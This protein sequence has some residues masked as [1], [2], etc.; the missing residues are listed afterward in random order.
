MDVWYVSYGSN[1]AA[2]RFGCYLS[3]GTPAGARRAM[4]GCRDARPPRR[5]RPT[6]LPWRLRFGGESTVWGGGVAYLDL[7]RPGTTYARAWRITVGQFADVIAQEND[8]ACGTVDVDTALLAAG[9]ALF[10]GESYGRVVPLPT[11]EGIPAVTFT[12]AELPPHRPPSPAY[13]STMRTGLLELSL[14][15]VD[16]DAYLDAAASGVHGEPTTTG[17]A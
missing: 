16:V 17:E 13:R 3:G 11:L 14:P 4:T 1:L 12:C 8:L 7:D 6:E 10:P 5:W 15:D 9:G 2:A